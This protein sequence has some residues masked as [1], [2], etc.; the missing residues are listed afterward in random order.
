MAADS[1]H[2][3]PRLSHFGFWDVDQSTLDYDKYANFVIIRVMER[4]NDQDMEEVIRYYGKE[5][6]IRELTS[7][8]SLMPTAIEAGKQLFHLKESDFKCYTTTPPKGNLS[9]Y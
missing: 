6:V 8:S 5:A 2:S 9:Q 1:N 3:K 4:G 7:A